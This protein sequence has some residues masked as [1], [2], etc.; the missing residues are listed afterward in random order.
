MIGLSAAILLLANGRI[1]GISGIAGSLLRLDG[2]DGTTERATFVIGL[3]GAPL[4]YAGLFGA[5]A[6]GLSAPT[7]QI[8]IGGLLVGVGVR[9]GAGCTSGHGVCG[10][11]RAS[12]RSFA[13][14]AVFMAVGA[15]TA[16]LVGG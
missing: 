6:I 15:A 13:A 5:P 2:A 7:A 11:T 10:M 8:V 14:V 4:L 1:A 12:P 9:M 16:T 3:V